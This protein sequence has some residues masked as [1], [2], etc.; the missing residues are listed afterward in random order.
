[1]PSRY[2]LPGSLLKARFYPNLPGPVLHFEQLKIRALPRGEP[3]V[4]RPSIKQHMSKGLVDGQTLA[5]K[6]RKNEAGK[7]WE[8]DS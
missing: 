6:G 8:G 5:R 3:R 7:G 1:M 2:L 4:T